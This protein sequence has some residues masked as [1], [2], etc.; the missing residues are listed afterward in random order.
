MKPLESLPYVVPPDDVECP[1]CE[2]CNSPELCAFCGD[3]IPRY[4]DSNY[5]SRT[6]YEA[7]GDGGA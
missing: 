2:Q 3:T 5:C 4:T 1:G 7:A 6:C